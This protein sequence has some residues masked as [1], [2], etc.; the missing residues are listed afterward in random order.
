MLSGCLLTPDQ[1]RGAWTIHLISNPSPAI[2]K[3]LNLCILIYVSLLGRINC[4][5]SISE[6]LRNL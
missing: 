5:L 1:A 6:N 3:L 2:C 4:S